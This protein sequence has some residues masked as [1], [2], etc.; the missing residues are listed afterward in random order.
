MSYTNSELKSNIGSGTKVIL[1]L[2]ALAIVSVI[3]VS[4]VSKE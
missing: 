3:A 2:S 1:L 4:C